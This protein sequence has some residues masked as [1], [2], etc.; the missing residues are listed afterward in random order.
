MRAVSWALLAGLMGCGVSEDKF[1]PQYVDLYCV[2]WLDCTDPA[3]L[4]F[5]G[6]D[7]IDHCLGTFGP[8]V[9]DKAQTCKLK[10]GRAKKCLN[11]MELLTC[12]SEGELDDVLPLICQD[13]WHKCLGDGAETSPDEGVNE[14]TG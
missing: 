12:P 7:G 11:D 5:D 2:V 10:K 1:V 8:I 13:V 3:E 6:V 9:A 4:V 14:D